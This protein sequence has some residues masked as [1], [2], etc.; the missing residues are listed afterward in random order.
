M[1]TSPLMLATTMSPL[2]NA[3]AGRAAHSANTRENAS[4]DLDERLM[5]E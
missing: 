2:S 5:A 4:S 3:S 1:C